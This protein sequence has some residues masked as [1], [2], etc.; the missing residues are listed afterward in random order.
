VTFFIHSY[1]FDIGL[2]IT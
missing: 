2:L 1:V